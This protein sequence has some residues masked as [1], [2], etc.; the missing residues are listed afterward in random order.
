MVYSLMHWVATVINPADFEVHKF[1]QMRLLAH[2]VLIFYS[3]VTNMIDLSDSLLLAYR[4]NINVRK[5]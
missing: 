5:C 3:Y 2:T 4:K 1:T